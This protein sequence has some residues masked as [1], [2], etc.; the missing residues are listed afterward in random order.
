V[1]FL[2]ATSLL[3]GCAIIN[4]L[5]AQVVSEPIS[6]FPIWVFVCLEPVISHSHLTCNFA[7]IEIKCQIE[8]SRHGGPDEQFA[9]GFSLHSMRILR[10]NNRSGKPVLP[11]LPKEILVQRPGPLNFRPIM[12][13]VMTMSIH[14]SLVSTEA[15]SFSSDDSV[16]PQLIEV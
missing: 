1:R 7:S 5:E 12:S 15:N 11:L 16:P 4:P 2:Y 8:E 3:S 13:F 14:R 10:S 6:G 9:D